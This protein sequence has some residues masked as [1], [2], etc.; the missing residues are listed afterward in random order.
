MIRYL[1]LVWNSASEAAEHLKRRF[2]ATRAEW[3][4]AVDV[5]GLALYVTTPE[6][7]IDRVYPVPGNRE[8]SSA[9]SSIS[10]ATKT[11]IQVSSD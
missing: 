3:T 5:D 11:S 7:S 1:A 8:P 6:N 2:V 4:T 10:H 9:S